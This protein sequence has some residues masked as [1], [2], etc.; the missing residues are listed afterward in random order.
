MNGG[1]VIELLWWCLV[2][3]FSGA[4]ILACTLYWIVF[5]FGL[6]MNVVNL[7]FLLQIFIGELD[8]FDGFGA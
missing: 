8:L 2:I 1:I 7:P 3:K 5:I 6:E 4:F